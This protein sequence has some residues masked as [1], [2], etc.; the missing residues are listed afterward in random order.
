MTSNVTDPISSHQ[1]VQIVKVDED[2]HS[3]YLDEEALEELLEDER[4]RDKPMCIVS[5]A[6]ELARSG[7]VRVVRCITV[8]VSIFITLSHRHL[9]P[10]KVISLGLF[11]PISE[12]HGHQRRPRGR[13][14]GRKRRKRS[15]GCLVGKSRRATPRLPLAM[16]ISTRH[17]GNSHVV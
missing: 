6:G 7:Y 10:G 11:P 8:L 13:R 2:D 15:T 9:S 16:W 1:G 3:F 17:H 5:V 12:L 4:I 14:G